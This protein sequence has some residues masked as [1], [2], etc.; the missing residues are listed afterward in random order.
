M[1]PQLIQ[2]FLESEDLPSGYGE[3]AERWILP[4]VEN[5]KARLAEYEGGRPFLLGVNGAQGTGKSTFSKLLSL[6]M[7]QD[8][9]QVCCLSIDDFYLSKQA[10]LDLAKTIHP[11]LATRG[12]PGTHDIPLLQECLSRLLDS[13]EQQTIPIPRFDKAMDDRTSEE[14]FH[15]QQLPVDL[16][17]LEGWCVGARFTESATL[18]E[19][20]NQLEAQEDADSSW[21]IFVNNCLRENYEPLFA[22]LDALVV[23]QAPSFEQVFEW[24]GLQEQKLRQNSNSDSGIMNEAK[25]QRFIQ[26]YERITR[27][28]LDQL[29]DRADV[30]F[31]IDES[32]RFTARKSSKSFANH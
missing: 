27:R 31:R 11:L 21:R 29:P 13:N 10:R 22:Q 6:L 28:C 20:L 2:Q 9:T 32:H 4:F 15:T 16:V 3:D 25:L 23:L 18:L 24:R 14:E 7:Q 17:I 8:Q 12:V 30:L 1:Y 19:P 5:L 26:H